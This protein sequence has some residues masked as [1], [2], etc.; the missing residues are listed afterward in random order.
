MVRRDYC[1]VMIHVRIADL[2]SRLSEYLR[3]VRRGNSITVL[4]RETPFAKIGPYG[5]KGL[6]LSVRAPLQGAPKLRNIP[7]PPPLK[8]RKHILHRLFEERQSER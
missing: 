8:L 1:L 4:D 7:L 6:F 2:K 5:E 3:N